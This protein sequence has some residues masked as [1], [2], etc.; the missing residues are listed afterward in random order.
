MDAQ[1]RA[2]R[3][4][5]QPGDIV[6]HNDAAP[7]N[8]VWREH[9]GTG[10]TDGVLIGFIDWDCAGPGPALRELAFVAFSWVPLTAPHVAAG[11]GFSDV[12]D[13]PRRLRLLL[14]AYGYQGDIDALLHAVKARIVDH[15]EGLVRL[16]ASGDPPFVRLVQRG[17]IEDLD[18]AIAQ[19][20]HDASRFHT[21]A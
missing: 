10:I 1:W 3:H 2:S 21:S 13:R 20:G 5:W 11:D 19:L 14:D 15:I 12:A 4:R 18:R 9:P 16:A 7:Y 17:V 6:G 8:A